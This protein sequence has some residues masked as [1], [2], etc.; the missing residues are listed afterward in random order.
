MAKKPSEPSLDDSTSTLGGRMLRYAKVSSQIGGVAAR[1][2]GARLA[3]RGDDAAAAEALRQAFGGLKGP[4][5]KVA[6]ILSSIPDMIPPVYA[7]ALAGLQADAPPMGWL[8]V[9]RRM[10]AELGPEWEKKFQS[11]EREAAAAASLGQVHRAVTLDGQKVACKLQYPD[12]QSA[13]EADLAQLRLIFGLFERYDKAVVTDMVQ[14]EIGA[15]LREELNYRQ[16][17]KH[18]ALYQAMLKDVKTA[19]VPTVH[20]DLSTDRL[21]VMRW[22]E[23]ER[24]AVAADSR[25]LAD[26]NDMAKALFR[27]WYIP[28][29]NYG[30]I[31]GDPHMGNYTVCPDNSINLLDYGCIRI[32]PAKLVQGVLTLYRALRDGREE[33]AVEAYRAWGFQNPS[34]AL[35]EALNIWA[36]FIYAPILE[37][38]TRAI[39]ETNSGRYG[40]ETAARVHEELRKIGGVTVPREFVFMDRAAVGL[41]AV[42]LRLKAEVNWYQEFQSL[43]QGF[44]ESA[45]EKRQKTLIKTVGL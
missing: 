35:V 19:H 38:R 33:Q 17:A 24:F 14:T 43:T 36:K 39:E 13:V 1:V 32:F 4:L 9:K 22:M 26:R 15:R 25:S 2:A 12:M 21:L 29:Y 8:F 5:M 30:V 40:K 18:I 28:F 41:G 11:F 42:F 34:K 6:Q 31:H 37:D 3:G 7:D 23:G 45:L 44:D 10:A 16:E 20:A 27:A